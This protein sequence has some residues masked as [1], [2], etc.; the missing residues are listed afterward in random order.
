M[1]TK[2]DDR[3]AKLLFGN[4]TVNFSRINNISNNGTTGILLN[5]VTKE[6]TTWCFMI[7]INF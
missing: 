2:Y 6:N 4:K 3:S 5:V 7:S 1:H